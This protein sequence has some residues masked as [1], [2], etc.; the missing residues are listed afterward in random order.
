MA[1]TVVAHSVLVQLATDAE[2]GNMVERETLMLVTYERDYI[3][4]H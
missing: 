2:P 1:N 3:C 4:A